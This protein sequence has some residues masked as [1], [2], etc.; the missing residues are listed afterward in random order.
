ML[1]YEILT[2]NDNN[3]WYR[4]GK[5]FASKQIHKEL[6]VPLLSDDNYYWFVCVFNNDIVGFAALEIKTNYGILKHAYVLSGFRKQGIYSHLLKMRVNKAKQ[7]KLSYIKTTAAP[8]TAKA[9]NNLG[10]IQT[11][12][13]GKYTNYRLEL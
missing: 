3:F 12:I 5:F 4:M 2:H 11:S 8:T 13:N 1:T 7:L 10:F 9:F 6:D